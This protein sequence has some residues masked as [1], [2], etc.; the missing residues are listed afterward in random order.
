MRDL[1]FLKLFYGLML[2]MV[3]AAFVSCVDD[4]DDTEAPFLEVSPTTLIFGLNGQPADGSQASFEIKANRSWKATVKEDKSWVTLSKT[5]GEGSATIQVSI[6]ENINDEASVVIEISNKVGV[7]MSKTVTIRSG[8][9]SPSVAIYHESAGTIAVASPWPLVGVYEGWA[10]TGPGSTNV[11]YSGTNT[12]VRSSGIA[13]DN[14]DQASGHN[15]VFFGTATASFVINKIALEADQ[16]NLRLTF[17]GSRSSR[18]DDGSYDNTFDASKFEVALSADGTNWVT[19]PYTKNNGDAASPYWVFATANFTLKEAVENIYIKFSATESSV[20]RLDDI[21][22][23]TGIGGD[24]IDLSGGGTEPGEATEISIPTIISMLT[25]V[26]T[27]LDA[28]ADRFFTAVVQSDVAG[29]NYTNNN[30]VVA[31]ENAT[32][33]GNGIV[34]YGSQVD[35]KTL[36]L[37]RGDKVKVT[38]LQGKAKI[39]NFKGV[40]EVTGAKEDTWATVE[41]VGTATITPIVI[42]PSSLK[43]YQG[44]TVTIKKATP[45]AAGI[46]GAG[47]SPYTF[48]ASGQEFA[49]FCK[50]GATAFVDQPFA[51]VESDITGLATVYT[52]AAQLAPR[53]MNDV[54]GFT[55]T[56]PTIVSVSPTSLTLA[57][58]GESKDITVVTVNQGSST[59]SATG[60]SGTL[61]ASVSGNTVTVKATANTGGVV[62]QTL[63]ISIQNGNSIT[64]PVSQIAASSGEMETLTMTS[65]DIVNGKT[66][67]V[68]LATNGYGS[69]LVSDPLTWYTW[70]F[71][72]AH[73]T[74]ARICIAPANNGGGIQVQGNASTQASQ[75]RIANT[76]ALPN[77]QSIQIVLRVVDTSTFEPAYNIYAGAT[78]NPSSSDTKISGT[79]TVDT[80]SG[81]KVYTQTYDLSNGSY[82]YFS[83]MND[84]A[85]ALYIDSI[86]ITYKK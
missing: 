6:P 21:T 65:Q 85:G 58:A 74:G 57:A 83:I 80:V 35:P 45:S 50:S 84:L 24:V 68:T 86:K 60:L 27:V 33:A 52:N 14:Y 49:V 62:N 36:A 64:V 7:L 51:L 31:T 44:M 42:A 15:S 26:E 40:Y 79:S 72:N 76:A 47:S 3:S 12:S 5:E 10:K 37:S 73:F 46:W 63:T 43:D 11:T 56:A 19:V 16:K 25:D 59:I 39:V 48:T 61:S 4:N 54:K 82:S 32:T 9:I 17:G 38:L 28:N 55:P 66:G 23:A 70:S 71:D 34:L 77:I 1:K 53:D 22:L 78:A 20:F 8:S 69:Q 67:T 18:G 81:F 75:G 13:S 30:L 29:G 41:K 2:V